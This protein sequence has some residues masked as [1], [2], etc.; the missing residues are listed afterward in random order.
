MIHILRHGTKK[1]G[2]TYKH[3]EK[4]IKTPEIL[5]YIKKLVIPPAYT[6]VTIIYPG[7]SNVK[8]PKIL[9]FGKDVAGRPQFIYSKWWSD[10]TRT[11]K[12]CH[13]IDFAKAYP[14][15]MSG[16]KAGMLSALKSKYM[17]KDH[18]TCIILAIISTCYFRV[19]NV[20][21]EK[22][23]KSYGISTITR[24]HVR[25]D[26]NG[27]R[28]KFI[29][30]KAVLNECVTVNQLIIQ[31]VTK[32]LY[33]VGSKPNDHVFMYYDTTTKSYIHIRHTHINNWLKNFDEVFTSKLFRT[34]DSNV[35][36]IN[37]LKTYPNDKATAR[38]QSLKNALIEVSAIVHNTPAI[39]KKDYVDPTLIKLYTDKPRSF[40]MQFPPSGA[41]L[42]QFIKYLEKS[43]KCK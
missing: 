26:N 30:K 42:Q 1:T 16:V 43:K 19:G 18:I 20:K 8:Q 23:Y 24:K 5:E 25:I 34:L 41:S 4:T 9:Y 13:L 14:K 10:A 21:Y 27:L 36:L 35:Y 17:D 37:K 32:L 22:L 38:K 15:I 6:D 3:E 31:C 12:Y 2:F 40:K 29:G 39:A 11:K 33:N 7:N 28:L